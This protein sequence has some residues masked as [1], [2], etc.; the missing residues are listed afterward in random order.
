M[1]PKIENDTVLIRGVDDKMTARINR[2]L[3]EKGIDVYRIE[4]HVLSLEDIFLK[5]TG[6]GGAL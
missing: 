2:L 6:K 4:E 1:K 5:L 3:I